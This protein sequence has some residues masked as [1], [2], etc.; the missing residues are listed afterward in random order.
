MRRLLVSVFFAMIPTLAYS[1]TYYV[2]KT[3]D[4]RNSCAQAQSE[5]SPKLTIGAGLGCVSSGDTLI[6][7][8]GTY[9]ENIP[10]TI[11]SGTSSART[12]VR[13][14]TGGVVILQPTV[15][16]AN[17][18]DAITIS[19]RSYITL[20]GLIVDAVNVANQGIRLSGNTSHVIIENGAVKNGGRGTNTASGHGIF[21]QDEGT[22]YNILRNLD[23]HNNGADS[24]EHGVYIR[25]SN[26]IVEK[27]RIYSNLGHGIHI[28]YS[29]NRAHNN[30]IRYNEVYGN[31]SWGILLGAGDGNIAHNNIVRNNGNGGMRTGFSK[32][33]DSQFY[34][35]T[36]YS[37]NGR[38]LH[39][40]SESTNA[41]LQNNICWKNTSDSILNEGTNTRMEA[42]LFDDP[43]FVDPS[44]AKFTL[45]AT[46]AAIKR[47]VQVSGITSD[48]A[49]TP[50]PSAAP[51]VGAYQYTGST[52]LAAPSNLRTSGN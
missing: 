26:N 34:Y 42:N 8:A 33:Q 12:T 9:A 41:V 52:G 24:L 10:N 28:F 29:S 35:N 43:S 16:T 6:I 23:I 45:R 19:G 22:V 4:D 3:G 17:A 14:A 21:L 31:G 51:D 7:K 5:S 13:A 37:N 44:A 2:A 32:P 15:G 40:R 47:G 1:A 39:V 38:C 27:C 50:I 30:I 11:P 48:L 20:D 46:S 36:I 18:N 25:S 49:G